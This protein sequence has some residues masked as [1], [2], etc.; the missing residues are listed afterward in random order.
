MGLW[1]FIG[2]A[3]R[4]GKVGTFTIK[5]GKEEK[6]IGRL[7]V[8]T[9]LS[10]AMVALLY[11]LIFGISFHL[12]GGLEF[13][14]ALLLYSAVGYFILPEPEYSNVGWFGGFMNNPFKLSDNANRFLVFLVIILMPGR[15][16][17]TTIVSWIDIRRR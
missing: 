6:R 1:E 16:I 12:K 7:I 8:K 2:E 17:S 13:A 14:A 10:T 3:I 9:I 11:Y 4:P 5:K 15:L